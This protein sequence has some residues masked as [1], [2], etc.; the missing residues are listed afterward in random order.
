[1]NTE[2]KK[3]ISIRLDGGLLELLSRVQET[4][5]TIYFGKTRTALIE[6][7]VKEHYKMYQ[8]NGANND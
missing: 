8:Q 7:A 3:M 4:P 6:T 5:N 2:N 1:M